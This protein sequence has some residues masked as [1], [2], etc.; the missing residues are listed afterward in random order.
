VPHL[1]LAALC[2]GI[3]S[4]NLGRAGWT[5]LALAT[6]CGAATLATSGGLRIAAAAVA[7]GAAGAW[8]GGARLDVIDR[9]LLA[10][11]AG[12]TKRV[13]AVTTAPA[14]RSAFA[15]RVFARTERV[16]RRRL[17]EPVLLELPRG[18]SPPQGARLEL[19][20]RV[21]LPARSSS[22]FDERAW[23][24]GR[25]VHVVL[26]GTRYRV[27]G[28]R[29]GVSGVA[30]RLHAWLAAT[31]AAGLHGERRGVIEG[32][33]LGE[34]AA[35][36]E[37]LRQAF[38]ASGLYHLLA[39]SGQNVAI[40]AASVGLLAW[41]LGLS[42]IGAEVCALAAVVAYVV[43]VG[44]QPSVVR[45]GVAGILTSLA[46]LCA[47]ERDRW[48]FFLA[49]AAVLLSWNP[50]NVRD[51]G[52]QLS[53]TA[54]AAIFVAVPRIRRV[55]DGYPVRPKLADAI[56]VSTACGVATAPIVL[57]QFGEVPLYAVLANALVAPVVA[58]LLCLA[59]A[60]AALAPFAPG[61]ALIVGWVAG[62]LAAYVAACARA[63]AALP[64]AQVGATAAA[65]VFVGAPLSLLVLSR[66]RP[67][68]ALRAGALAIV[69]ASLLVAWRPVVDPP[70][71]AP[72]GFRLTMLDVGQGD[73]ILLETPAAA[74]LVDQ[75]IP[76]AHVADDL[77]RLGVD[78]LDLL[79]LTHPQRDHVGGAAEVLEEL[80]V[81]AILDPLLAASSEDHR[82]ALR[83]AR[84]RGVPIIVARAGR[85]IT[86]GRLRL[87]V[88][89]PPD[90]GSAGEDPNLN[91]TVIHASYGDL[92][93]LLTAD[94]ESG[95][96][97]PLRLPPAEILKVAHHGSADEGLEALLRQ[98]R[99]RLALISCGEDNEYG[100]PAPSTL[101]ALA[102]VPALRLYR[103]DR[104]GT[105]VV[106]ADAGGLRV[107][108]KH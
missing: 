101:S 80:R 83:V 38:R 88:L 49:G 18:R 73:A 108:E 65:V 6:A 30:D 31:V 75:G 100:H 24:R 1:L 54:V 103:T 96:T 26:R 102:A 63:V 35:L 76:E 14:R 20:A 7:L 61:A 59:L 68:R 90:A 3:A 64:F 27:V 10:P 94:A 85:T 17:E 95:V 2:L 97:L 55:L 91:A 104:D 5:A 25:G 99:P 43:A 89:W 53:F 46:W 48:W 79:V 77:Q 86:L 71:S 21:E 66:L 16:G 13:T 98:T 40:V 29:G 4:A 28:R 41:L 52:F 87:A 56:A 70:L 47:R 72:A 39:V 58:P 15:V 67:P 81:D 9:S 33:V 12:S 62:W 74:V 106:E 60:S 42:R 82:A 69:V 37:R 78:E 92:D 107:E 105:V 34:D 57:A 84:R 93:A 50:Y 23:L 19:V 44:W 8:W 51:A 36:S 22:G 11:L 45:A 32:V